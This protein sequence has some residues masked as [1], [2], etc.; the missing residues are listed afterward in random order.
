[1]TP[2]ARVAAAIDILDRHLGGEAAEA[3]LTQWARA[4]RYAGSGDRAAVRDHVYDAL[5][6][7]RSYAVLGGALTGRGLMRGRCA[8]QGIDADSIFT[9]SRFAPEALT[10]A[11]RAPPVAPVGLD[12]LDC[13][14]WLAPALRASLGDDFAPV[15]AAQRQRAPLFLRVNAAHATRP[16]AIAALAADGIVAKPR[17]E[18]SFALQVTENARKVAVSM[19]YA[20]G[21][22]EVQDLSSQAAVAALPLRPGMRVLDYCAGGG[23]KLLAMAARA[24]GDYCAHDADPARMRDLPA[25]AARAGVAPRLVDPGQA[26][27]GQD[28]VL[29]DAPCSGSGTWRRT[30]EAKWRL[31]A[32]RLAELVAVQR[33]IL[34]EAQAHVS[35]TGVLAYMTCSLLRSEN[36]DQASHFLAANPGWRLAQARRFSPLGGGDGFYLAVFARNGHDGHT[37]GLYMVSA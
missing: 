35:A 5:R 14:D 19:T 37:Q 15:M 18:V 10:E 7:R 26:P 17:D 34:A 23:G 36:E 24:P 21:V 20:Q 28:L 16:E 8:A 3:A 12:A 4:N 1:M 11:E 33:K 29:V 25:R 27:G 32:A 2:A 31:T 9:G 22:V 13:P 6:C 30:P